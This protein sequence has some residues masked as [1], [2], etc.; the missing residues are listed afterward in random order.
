M[1]ALSGWGRTRKFWVLAAIG[2]LVVLLPTVVVAQG[3]SISAGNQHP[4]VDEQPS[5]SAL[6]S[7]TRPGVCAELSTD[8]VVRDVVRAEAILAR[9][10][11]TISPPSGMPISGY[12]CTGGGPIDDQQIFS[13]GLHVSLS[14]GRQAVIDY[15]NPSRADAVMSDFTTN[16]DDAL[17]IGADSPGVPVRVAPNAIVVSI[18]DVSDIDFAMIS[19][20]NELDYR[21]SAEALVGLQD[22]MSR[23]RESPGG[24]PSQVL[25]GDSGQLVEVAP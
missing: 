1:V 18:D 24:R 22:V 6:D 13:L 16:V 21:T 25:M 2:G 12:S 14:N 23:Y 5:Q 20:V 4:L 19:E 10:G 15:V 9:S 7:L 3:R 17:K 11:V 8:L